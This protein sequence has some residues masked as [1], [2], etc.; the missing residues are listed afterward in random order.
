MEYSIKY[1]LH[2]D[3]SPVIDSFKTEEERNSA[4]KKKKQE[5]YNP[6]KISSGIE[7]IKKHL[8]Q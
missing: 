1:N 3:K 7:S 5:G 2:K 4:I 8:N 6:I